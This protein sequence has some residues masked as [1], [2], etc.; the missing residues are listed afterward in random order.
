MKILWICGLPHEVQARALG[1]QDHGAYAA[2]SWIMGHLPPPPGVELHIACRT[3]RHTNY[4]QLEYGGAQFHLVPVRARARVLCL[5]HFDWRYFRDLVQR[6]QPEVIHG[7]GTEDAYANVALRLAPKNHLIQIQGCI[8]ACRARSKM[9]WVTRFSAI[10]ERRD[11]AQA[12]HVAAENDYSLS[13]A[14]PFIHTNSL[15]VVEHPLRA[16]FLKATP[17]S[18]DAR[19][20]LYV[21]VIEE[22]K[23][24]WDALATFQQAAP[25]DWKMTVVGGGRPHNLDE[26]RRRLAAPEVAAR[27]THHEQLPAERIVQLMQASSVFLLPTWVDTGPTTL[28]EAMAMGLWPVC[29]DNTGPAHYLRKFQFGT[30]A[31]DLNR[32]DLTDKLKQV[33]AAQ[34]WRQPAER[35]KLESLIRPHFRRERIWEDLQKLYRHI[36]TTSA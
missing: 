36:I 27:V 8:N 3:S 6:L 11:L 23:G 29:F 10:S 1:G 17:A 33:F 26:L 18:G 28:K 9:H 24:I 14:R 13:C 30:L 15:H 4:R 5:F 21:G 16:E 32:V 22:R 20:V 19:H 2:W 34:P 35:E 7:W 12:R 31:E 25:P